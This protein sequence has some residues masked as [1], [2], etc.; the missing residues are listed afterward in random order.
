MNAVRRANVGLGLGLFSFVLWPFAYVWLLAP[1]NN[2]DWFGVM[3][4]VA[5]W[6]AL[7]CAL[8]AIWLGRRRTQSR[9]GIARCDMDPRLGL[10]TIGLYAITFLAVA[11]TYR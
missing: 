3:I 5:E 7:I 6:G 4:P 2:P 8:A 9:T 1:C 10:A 11:A